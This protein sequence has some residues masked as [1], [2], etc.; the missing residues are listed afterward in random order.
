MSMTVGEHDGAWLN[1]YNRVL[2]GIWNELNKNNELL[3]L[4]Q[5]W[6][7]EV[8]TDK[9]YAK[10]MLYI[11]NKYYWKLDDDDLTEKAKE[12]A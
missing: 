9:A 7:S 4:K 12:F 10:A 3:V 1:V 2:P 8:I 6:E 11:C 5:L